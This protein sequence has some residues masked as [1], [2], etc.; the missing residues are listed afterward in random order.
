MEKYTLG[1]DSLEPDTL[2]PDQQILQIT[3]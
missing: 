2:P 3:I 1:P